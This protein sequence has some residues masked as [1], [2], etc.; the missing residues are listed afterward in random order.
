MPSSYLYLNGLRLHYLQWNVETGQQP[1]VALHGLASN[2]R[3]WE[4]AAPFLAEHGFRLYAP[5]QRGHGLTDKPEGDYGFDV[6]RGDLLA[7][8]DA[9][10]L[11]RPILLGHS[12]G[13]LVALDFAAHYTVG[14]RAPAGVV[15]VDGGVI[16]LDDGPDASWELVQ[17]RLTPPRLAGMPLDDFLD[18]LTDWGGP[19]GADKQ[20]VQ[21]ILSNFEINEDETIAPRLSFEHHMQIVRAMWEFKTFESLQRLRCPVEAVLAEPPP[22]RSQADEEFLSR[23]R[24]GAARAQGVQPRLS[25][26]WLAETLHDIPLHRPGELANLILEFT[27]GIL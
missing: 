23:K 3:I 20:A 12:W 17:R 26:H 25:I 9:C 14:P 27:R 21:I 8:L 2:A 10:Q 4:L 16:Q 6:F 1:I 24:E 11:E 15:L 7:F 19:L 22:G 5:D 13:A 18:R